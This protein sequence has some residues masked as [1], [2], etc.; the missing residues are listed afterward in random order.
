MERI[1]PTNF[2][3]SST[4]EL[5]E[6]VKRAFSI[7]EDDIKA[8]RYPVTDFTWWF[9]SELVLLRTGQENPFSCRPGYAT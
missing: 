9:Y 7:T 5:G 1:C 6:K 3:V 2:E 8:G 4:S